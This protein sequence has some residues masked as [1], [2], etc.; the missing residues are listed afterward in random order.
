MM[1][2]NACTGALNDW[3]DPDVVLERGV[4]AVGRIADAGR[5]SGIRTTVGEIF[6]DTLGIGK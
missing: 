6:T 3:C 5:G 1:R 2:Q 4:G